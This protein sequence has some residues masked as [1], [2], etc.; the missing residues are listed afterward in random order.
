MCVREAD[1]RHLCPPNDT[2]LH[3]CGVFCRLCLSLSAESVVGC[4]PFSFTLM[5]PEPRRTISPVQVI[6]FFFFFCRTKSDPLH[7][8]RHCHL[9]LLLFSICLACIKARGRFAERVSDCDV[10][11]FFHADSHC[12][13]DQFTVLDGKFCSSFLTCVHQ[14]SNLESVPRHTWRISP[15]EPWFLSFP[16]LIH[17]SN[18]TFL[19]SPL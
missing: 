16:P 13:F 10:F 5:R 6:A 3:L 12:L 14:I 1:A 18:M 19:P 7:S 15:T 9:S 11:D 2:Y 4:L 8:D 17:Y